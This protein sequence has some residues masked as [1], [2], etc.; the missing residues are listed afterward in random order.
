LPAT[1]HPAA[2]SGSGPTHR[3]ANFVATSQWAD[4]PARVRHEAKRSILNFFGTALGGSRDPATEAATAVLSRFAARPEAGLI[5][6]S[7][8]VG[9]LDAAFLNAISGNVFDFDDTHY[10]T[11]IHPTAPVSPPLFALAERQRLSGEGVLHAFVLGVEIECRLGNAVSP[12]HYSRGWHITSTCGVFGSAAA[13]AKVLG[14][15]VERIVWAMGNAAAQSAGLIENLGTMAKSISVGSAARGGML[16]AFLAE[17]GVAGPAEPIS[18][19]RGF[20]SVMADEANVAELT[21]GLGEA[22]ELLDN[23]YKPYPCGVVLNPVIDACLELRDRPGLVRDQVSRVVVEGHPLLRQRADRPGVT[24]GREAQVSAQHT[25]AVVFLRGAAGVREYS[26][27]AVNA[28]DIRAFAERVE[29]AENG[30]IPVGAAQVRV[31]LASGA[32][33]LA[34]VDD[35]RGSPTKPLTDSEIEAKVRDLAAFGCPS[36]DPEPLIAAIWA[37]D[38]CDDAGALMALTRTR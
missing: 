15:D 30:A 19:P 4:V 10:R 21:K 33:L 32:E 1:I 24:T 38:R 37:L 26:D 35:A 12:G 36:L 8:R 17:A 9:T 14:L 7:E 13:T 6:R 20:T 5:G 27:T 18:G 34:R 16:A 23:A 31:E 2:A 22:W 3:I 25:V 29:V 11:I 28:P